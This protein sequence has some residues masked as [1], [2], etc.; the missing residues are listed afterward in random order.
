MRVFNKPNV[1]NGWKCPICNTNKKKEVVL[2]IIDGTK[3]GTIA[4]AEQVHLECIE[5]RLSKEYTKDIDLLYQFI[6]KEV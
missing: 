3:E 2:I 5:L 4:E 6:E 1:S